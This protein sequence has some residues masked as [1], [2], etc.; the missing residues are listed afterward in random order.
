MSIE[1]WNEVIPEIL[2]ELGINLDDKIVYKLADMINDADDMQ[3]E[4]SGENYYTVGFPQEQQDDKD[5]IIRD[6]ERDLL[7]VRSCLEVVN[8]NI[9]EGNII[10]KDRSKMSYMHSHKRMNYKLCFEKIYKNDDLQDL[11]RDI[12]ESFDPEFNADAVI[13][14]NG[15]YEVTIKWID[16]G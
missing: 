11:S 5:K 15:S 4:Y 9:K 6:L 3:G 1:Y 7:W 16:E 14:K 12:I 13:E 8:I 10:L 2:H